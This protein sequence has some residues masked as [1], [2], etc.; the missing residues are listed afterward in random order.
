MRSSFYKLIVV[1]FSL[2]F[3]LSAYS[4]TSPVDSTGSRPA[5]D[6]YKKITSMKIRDVQK[7]T[8]KKMKLR[9]KIAFSV[10][11]HKMKKKESRSSQGKTAL[12]F[13]IGGLALLVGGLFVPYIILGA[14]AASIVAIVVG[15]NASKKNPED[16][17]ANAGKLLGWI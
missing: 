10:L 8:G 5:A 4:S 11:K 17:Q 3:C 7:L 12:I 1:C 13:G 14:L 16:R 2:F 9:E 6:F 15:S